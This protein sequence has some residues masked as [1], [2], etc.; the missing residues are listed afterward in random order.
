MMMTFR[1][2]LQDKHILE[3][4][5]LQ[6]YSVQSAT[7]NDYQGLLTHSKQLYLYFHLF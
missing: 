2:N 6:C 1:I 3:H 7:F 5:M 4:H